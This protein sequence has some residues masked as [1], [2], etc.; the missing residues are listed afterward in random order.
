MKIVGILLII[1]GFIIA[2]WAN[3]NREQEISFAI[4]IC[5][6]LI[7]FVGLILTIYK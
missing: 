7:C 1:F 6:F 4:G 2:D 5:A 3:R